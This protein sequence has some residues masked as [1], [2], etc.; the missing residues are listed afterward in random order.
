MPSAALVTQ[1]LRPAEKRGA[2]DDMKQLQFRRELFQN[3]GLSMNSA[4]SSA[5]LARLTRLKNPH[6]IA[7]MARFGIVGEGRLGISMPVL[8]AIAK[9]TGRNHQL[10]LDLWETHIPEAMI[11]ASM[12]AEP[13]KL[14][15][16]QADAMAKSFTSWDVCDQM[17]LNLFVKSSIAWNL[18]PRWARH[19]EEFVK[20]AAFS[21]IA[22][23]AVHDKAAQDRRFVAALKLVERASTDERNFVKKAVNWALRGIGKRNQALLAKAMGTATKLQKSPSRSAR[24]IATDALREFENPNI[25]R[26]IKPSAGR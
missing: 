23:L 4:N 10:A 1:I 2:Q 6:N 3:S 22:C 17:C 19:R 25:R 21:L 18:V 20:R 8:R 9:E 5:T 14:T 12:V 16:T 24:W 13:G 7:G 11:V 15:T 26:R